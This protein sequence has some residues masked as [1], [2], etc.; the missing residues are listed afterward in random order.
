MK[1][2]ACY[3]VF[4]GLGLVTRGGFAERPDALPADAQKVVLV[5]RGGATP[6]NDNRRTGKSHPYYC[7]VQKLSTSWAFDNPAT[8]IEQHEVYFVETG[9]ALASFRF[10]NVG[11]VGIEAAALIV[12]YLD[13]QGQTI[14]EISVAGTSKMAAEKFH[15]PFPVE[16]TGVYLKGVQEGEHWEGAVPPGGSVLLAGSK[17]GIRTGQCPVAG[18]V[19][20]LM[21]QFTGG[22]VRTFSSPSWRLG[23][24]PRRIPE[25]PAAFRPLPTLNRPSSLLARVKISASGAVVDVMPDDKNSQPEVLR[26]IRDLMEQEW[27]FHPGLSGGKPVDSELAVLFR[28][29][30]DATPAFPETEPTLSPVTLI[31]FFRK[32]DLYPNNY[33]GSDLVVMYG[34]AEEGSVV[35]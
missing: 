18:K 19:T 3:V 15:A 9:H 25:V 34:L 32:H 27:R 4:L 28:F 12:E 29:P 35:E 23:P 33:T 10:R 7:H 21:L 26:W 16:T 6:S 13:E 20:F 1:S 8:A 17:N 30:A 22:S 2:S 31:Q 24:I 11:G 14:D 5:D